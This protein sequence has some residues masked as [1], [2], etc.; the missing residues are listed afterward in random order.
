MVDHIVFRRFC[1]ALQP[2]FKL[3][4]RNIIKKDILDM[5]EVQRKALV[6]YF[7]RCKSRIVVTTD[8]QTANHQKKG[9]MY[10]TVYFIDDD[11]KLK[12]FL[13]R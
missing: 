9:Y 5:Y 1:A 8:M 11:W 6:S 4:S 2:L 3:V 13:L 7:Q 12:S 10:V